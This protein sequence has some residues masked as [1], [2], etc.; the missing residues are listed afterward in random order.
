[1][2]T[3]QNSL[4]FWNFCRSGGMST[5]AIKNHAVKRVTEI[6]FLGVIMDQINTQ[7]WTCWKHSSVGKTCH[8]LTHKARLLVYS[9]IILPCLQYSADV[10]ENTYKTNLQS[11]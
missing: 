11:L 9:L 6:R 8:T 10:W 7:S 5:V 2:L 1:M 3:K 4:L